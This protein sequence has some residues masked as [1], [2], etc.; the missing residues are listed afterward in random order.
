MTAKLMEP[1]TN[2]M[3]TFL[4]TIDMGSEVKQKEFGEAEQL[5]ISQY[6]S[7]SFPTSLDEFH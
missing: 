2:Y 3:F 7:A 4:Y 1:T 6:L 5:I